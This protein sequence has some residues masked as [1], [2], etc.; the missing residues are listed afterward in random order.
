MSDGTPQ[1]TRMLKDLAPGTASSNPRTF[2]NCWDVVYFA[3]DSGL[4]ASRD[5]S[6]ERLVNMGAT[7]PLGLLNPGTFTCHNG[8]FVFTQADTSGGSEPWYFPPWPMT[9]AAPAARR[10]A[11]VKPGPSGSNPSNFVSCGTA[12]FFTADDGV[13]GE[14]LWT[15]SGAQDAPPTLVA[16]LNPGSSGAGFGSSLVCLANSVLF[17]AG[18]NGATGPE[19]W[20]Y[21]LGI[22]AAPTP[23]EVVPGDAG[24]SPSSFVA[25]GRDVFF[26][27][28]A[29]GLTELF[30]I[31]AGLD[32]GASPS[33]FLRFGSSPGSG[34]PRALTVAG[35]RLFFL[36]TTDA[37]L[38]RPWS[39]AGTAVEPLLP[40]Q[41]N[42]C[43]MSK[44]VPLP[45][46]GVLMYGVSCANGTPQWW[47]YDPGTKTMYAVGTGV[48]I[49]GSLQFGRDVAILGGK[50]LVAGRSLATGREPLIADSV[51]V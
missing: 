35:G 10:V 33:V 46:G 31:P 15:W 25:R 18:N 16:D 47:H 40:A 34:S 43:S 20:R 5:G 7:S 50:V 9:G 19:P 13:H 11:D 6:S 3:T 48:T 24:S 37:G 29:G 39:S 26:V 27:A 14:E 42:P 45:A 44:F 23:L 49:G 38:E 1:G 32:S 17:F 21:R 36:A 12:L 2:T 8:R 22:D 4:Y 30:S 41:L 51:W 28:T